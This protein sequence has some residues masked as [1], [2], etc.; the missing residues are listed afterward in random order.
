MSLTSEC[1]IRFVEEDSGF[2]IAHLPSG[3]RVKFV[4]TRDRVFADWSLHAILSNDAKYM[5]WHESDHLRLAMW[6]L[7]EKRRYDIIR[8]VMT[9]SKLAKRL[10]ED[11]WVVNRGRSQGG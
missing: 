7:A 9:A 6:F 5:E 3:A 8:E 11:G 10:G 1:R 2:L 4:A